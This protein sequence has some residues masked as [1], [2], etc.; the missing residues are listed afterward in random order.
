MFNVEILTLNGVCF[1]PLC[2]VF[3]GAFQAHISAY[4]IGKKNIV[5]IRIQWL[6]LTLVK[7]P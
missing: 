1:V 7:S 3:L 2:K 4:I 5:F 6:K